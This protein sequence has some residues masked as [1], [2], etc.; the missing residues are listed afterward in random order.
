MHCLS[1]AVH[2]SFYVDDGLVGV[3]SIADV[4]VP[5]RQLHDYV[6]DLLC[7]NGRVMTPRRLNM[8]QRSY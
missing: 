2:L 3:D 6:V 7:Q 1:Q 5:Q 4:I 8:C